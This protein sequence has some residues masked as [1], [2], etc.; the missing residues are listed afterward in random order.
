MALSQFPRKR[1]PRPQGV[2]YATVLGPRGTEK[3]FGFTDAEVASRPLPS[4]EWGPDE[5]FGRP[6]RSPLDNLLRSEMSDEN[7]KMKDAFG[8]EGVHFIGDILDHKE[9]FD[10]YPELTLTRVVFDPSLEGG[11]Y[12]RDRR[13]IGVGM[14]SNSPAEVLMHELQ[15]AVQTT[16]GMV[17]GA[18]YYR[19]MDEAK[20]QNPGKS[21]KD[22]R[23][24]VW[25]FY[26]SNLGEQEAELTA[27]RS[28]WG[29]GEFW[30]SEEPHTVGVDTSGEHLGKVLR[31]YFMSK[32]PKSPLDVPTASRGVDPLAARAMFLRRFQEAR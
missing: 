28:P 29:T 9:L 16:E 31:E 27:A 6:W 17:P 15:H 25:E 10:I 5:R 19:M 32:A 1:Q 12:D 14:K 18:N 23:R 8:S 20:R 2:D 7:A 30:E 24:S 26:A 3:A 13:I 4:A 22:L 11:Y 21:E